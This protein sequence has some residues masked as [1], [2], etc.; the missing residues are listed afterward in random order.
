MSASTSRTDEK[1]P[2]MQEIVLGCCSNTLEVAYSTR[3]RKWK[4]L[5]MNIFECMSPISIQMEFLNLCQDGK[6]HKSAQA[7]S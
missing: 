3:V 1:T 5:F 4:W 6:K 7:L 2:S